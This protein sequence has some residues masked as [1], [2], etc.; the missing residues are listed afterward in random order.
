MKAAGHIKLCDDAIL[1]IGA[2]AVKKAIA[3][4]EEKKEDDLDLFGDDDGDEDSAAATKKVAELAKEAAKKKGK[5][6]VIAKSSV[7]LEVKPLDD[8]TNLD[9]LAQKIFTEIT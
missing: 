1:P 4:K 2:V 6:E 8:T 7:T 5:K 3:K 9:D